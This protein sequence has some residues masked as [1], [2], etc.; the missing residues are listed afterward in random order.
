MHADK[1]IA[2]SEHEVL[3]RFANKT[4]IFSEHEVFK[5]IVIL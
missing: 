4:I 2:F 5:V 1:N 3:K